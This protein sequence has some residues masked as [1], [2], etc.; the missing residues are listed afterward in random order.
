VLRKLLGKV[1]GADT[2]NSKA[3]VPTG[4]IIRDSTARPPG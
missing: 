4:L 2:G 1:S 3:L